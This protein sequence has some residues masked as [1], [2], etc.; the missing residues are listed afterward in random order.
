MQGWLLDLGALVLAWIGVRVVFGAALGGRPVRR[1]RTV[2][3]LTWVVSRVRRAPAP[4]AVPLHRPI[5][6]VGPDVRRL[7]EAFHRDGMRF[8]KYEGC[9]LAYDAVLAEAADILEI[10]HLLAVLS[11]GAERDLERERV[12]HL[13]DRAGMSLRPRAA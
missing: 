10:D 8:A 11:P 7:H 3:A 13:L 1:W 9:R 4:V 5:E 6:K 2:R 12:E